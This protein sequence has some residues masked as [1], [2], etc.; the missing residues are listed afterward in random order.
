MVFD[1]VWDRKVC[2]HMQPLKAL[3][4]KRVVPSRRPI[5]ALQVAVELLTEIAR[6]TAQIEGAVPRWLPCTADN[7]RSARRRFVAGAHSSE[8]GYWRQNGS[9]ARIAGSDGADVGFR[10]RRREGVRFVRKEVS[11]PQ[12]FSSLGHTVPQSV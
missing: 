4:I 12:G 2:R 5:I 8:I 7:D 10:E 9:A 11:E 6:S 1:S 3:G